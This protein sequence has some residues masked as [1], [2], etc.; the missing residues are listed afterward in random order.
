MLDLEC[1]L[2][3]GTPEM[4]IARSDRRDRPDRNLFLGYSCHPHAVMDAL[5][6]STEGQVLTHP[7]SHTANGESWIEREPC[8]YRSP[9]L[10]QRAE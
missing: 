8:P 3:K 7:A 1:L 10:L 6:P 4:I 5:A 2:S 9:C